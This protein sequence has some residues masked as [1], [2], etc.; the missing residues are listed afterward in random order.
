MASEFI[1]NKIVS[2][3]WV[4]KGFYVKGGRFYFATQEYDT[5]DGK[6]AV[7]FTTDM[8]FLFHDDNGNFSM[9]DM[10]SFA[11]GA[12]NVGTRFPCDYDDNY[13][14]LVRPY[15]GESGFI[16]TAKLEALGLTEYTEDMIARV[17]DLADYDKGYD[18]ATGEDLD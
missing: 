17:K 11:S 18:K 2:K 12:G 5:N 14:V 1:V 8:A 15:A 7:F 3:E 6:V 4:K 9:K 10:M 16:N 13:D